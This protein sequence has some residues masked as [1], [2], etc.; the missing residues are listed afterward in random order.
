MILT[1]PF[2]SEFCIIYHCKKNI[3][4]RVFHLKHHFS[5]RKHLNLHA[6]IIIDLFSKEDLMDSKDIFVYSIQ[7]LWEKTIYSEVSKFLAIFILLLAWGSLLYVIYYVTIHVMLNE[8][9]EWKYSV[10]I[11][12]TTLTFMLF[13]FLIT[14]DAI[15]S[16]KWNI[17][18][19]AHETPKGG[20]CKFCLT[21]KF[22]L[23]VLVMNIYWIRNWGLLVSAGT[24]INC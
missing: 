13:E 17:M 7:Y 9:G 15:A 1:L 10:L 11:H 12:D 23:L 20:I 3:W 22:W 6:C 19:V 24:K 14:M 21:E 18:S 16:I 2:S 5:P 8:I 4:G